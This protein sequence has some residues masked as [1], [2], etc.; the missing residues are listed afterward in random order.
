MVKNDADGVFPVI[1]EYRDA[2]NFPYS[3]S[4]TGRGNGTVTCYV[5]DVQQWSQGVNFSE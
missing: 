3:I 1:D 2:E 5:N 4:V